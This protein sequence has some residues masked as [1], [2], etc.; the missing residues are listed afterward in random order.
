MGLVED[1]NAVVDQIAV[2]LQNSNIEKIVVGH[3]K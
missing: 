1:E 3:D 2:S